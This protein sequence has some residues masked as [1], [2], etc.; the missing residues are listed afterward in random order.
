[1][2]V[3]EV[4]KF[5]NSAVPLVNIMANRTAF[6]PFMYFRHE[7]VLITTPKAVPFRKDVNTLDIQGLLLLFVVLRLHKTSSITFKMDAIR[8]VHSL[9]QQIACIKEKISLLH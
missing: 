1:M 2:A 5:T 7:D 9:A 8:G 3:A 4:A 6:R